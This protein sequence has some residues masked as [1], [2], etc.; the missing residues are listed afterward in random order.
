MV[1][2]VEVLLKMNE[3]YH[4]VDFLA[5]SRVLRDLCL[6]GKAPMVVMTTT[7]TSLRRV[8]SFEQPGWWCEEFQ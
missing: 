2:L 1:V 7:T 4:I 6:A 3:L 8:H 5:D